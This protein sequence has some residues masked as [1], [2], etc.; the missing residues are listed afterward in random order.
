[1]H[2][3]RHPEGYDLAVI[4]AC[5]SRPEKTRKCL[6]QLG[7]ALRVAGLDAVVVVADSSP[8]SATADLLRKTQP[9]VVLIETDVN[10]FW[11]C[12]MRKA[13]LRAL[14]FEW[15]YLLWLNDD[16]FLNP[17]ALS[18]LIRVEKGS[19]GPALAIGATKDPDTGL[20]TYGLA[21]R[22]NRFF[23]RLKLVAIPPGRASTGFFGNGNALLVRREVDELIG[24]FPERF[25]H[26]MADLW[27]TG[28]ARKNGV[29]L[30]T[31]EKYVG[32]C[33][34]NN[35]WEAWEKETCFR[36]M[37]LFLGV[38]GF[39]LPQWNQMALRFGGVMYPALVISPYLGR[40]LRCLAKKFARLRP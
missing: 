28:T 34:K 39:P 22:K 8:D 21:A 38:K 40:L 37:R 3:S 10:C 6:N 27:Y 1:M 11:A 12:G 25:N 16:T 15:D 7:V 32:Y 4:V 19:P 2:S 9:D 24:G 30:L 35:E 5:H 17:D 18:E 13:Y 33:S 31:P 36:Q 26:G 14:E 20:M 23:G 29:T